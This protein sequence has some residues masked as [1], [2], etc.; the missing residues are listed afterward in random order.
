MTIRNLVERATSGIHGALLKHTETGKQQLESSSATEAEAQG[1]TSPV[2]GQASHSSA[3]SHLLPS[4]FDDSDLL[5]TGAKAVNHLDVLGAYMMDFTSI[6]DTHIEAQQRA[7]RQ[8]QQQ[9]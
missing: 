9:Q 5:V 4:L 3:G 7:K 1:N 8:A 6:V 2:K